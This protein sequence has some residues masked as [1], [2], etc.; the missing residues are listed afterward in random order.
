MERSDR[1]L[2]EEKKRGPAETAPQPG[3]MCWTGSLYISLPFGPS[4]ATLPYEGSSSRSTCSKQ[5]A[6]G[7]QPPRPA[8]IVFQTDALTYERGFCKEFSPVQ[9]IKNTFWKLCDW[10]CGAECAAPNCTRIWLEWFH[11][12]TKCVKQWAGAMREDDTWLE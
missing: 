5:N 10:V 8:R 6:I 9:T 1:P 7:A 12:Q 11:V 3:T 2:K 4:N